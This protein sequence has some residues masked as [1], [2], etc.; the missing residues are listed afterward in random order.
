[1]AEIPVT[2]IHGHVEKNEQL[3]GIRSTIPTIDFP[4]CIFIKVIN[5]FRQHNATRR[6]CVVVASLLNPI[7]LSRFSFLFLPPSNLNLVAYFTS[8]LFIIIFFFTIHFQSSD[9]WSRSQR[10]GTNKFFAIERRKACLSARNGNIDRA[11]L[12]QLSSMSPEYQEASIFVKS[13]GTRRKLFQRT[14]QK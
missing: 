13:L 2:E 7:S 11:L 1:M 12:K 3:V 6:C 8:Y 5:I 10:K 9:R 14:E 4:H